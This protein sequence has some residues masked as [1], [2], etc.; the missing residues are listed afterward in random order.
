MTRLRRAA[1]IAF[2]LHLLAGISMAFVLR[3][4][5]E[6]NGNLQDRLVF[7]VNHRALW[8]GAWFSWAASA[9]AILYF[10]MAFAE[11]HQPA[12]RFAVL[13][14]VAGLGP[15]LAAQAI[16]IG[17]LPSI[18]NHAFSTNAGVELFLTLHRIAV[19]LSGCLANGLY[20]LTALLLTCFT[21]RTYSWWVFVPGFAVA[22]LGFALSAAV[23]LDSVAGMFWTN[24][25]LVP[26]ILF[27][28]AAVAVFANSGQR[29]KPQQK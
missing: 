9:L 27:W 1:I 8:T 12:L 16:E 2:W 29:C 14:T 6:T 25:L 20:S 13:L 5:L 23:L 24:V 11:T 22:I 26:G 21:R 7:L 17:V 18:A 4:G 19:M 10:Y 15:D 28:L 3:H